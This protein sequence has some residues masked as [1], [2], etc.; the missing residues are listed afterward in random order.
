[1]IGNYLF[2]I[3]LYHYGAYIVSILFNRGKREEMRSHN[4]K[5]NKLRT[6]RFKT[7]EEQ[8]EFA[9]YVRP[10]WDVKFDLSFF[11]GMFIGLVKFIILLRIYLYIIT[12]FNINVSILIAVLSWIIIPLSM[13]FILMRFNLENDNT[14][15]LFKWR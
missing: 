8:K 13:N 14:V 9:N 10:K 7:L 6:K 4:E 3:L 2:F 11:K 12:Y 15:H 5:I 1:M